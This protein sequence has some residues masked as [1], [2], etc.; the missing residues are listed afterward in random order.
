[1]IGNLYSPG[2]NQRVYHEY[3]NRFLNIGALSRTF[4]DI[5]L[6]KKPVRTAPYW[7]LLRRDLD[8][9]LSGNIN[10]LFDSN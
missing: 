3:F 8:E 1:M 6:R 4:H 10:Y 7:W 2:N 5:G 9:A